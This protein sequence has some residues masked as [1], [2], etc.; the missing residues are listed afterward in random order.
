MKLLSKLKSILAFPP[1]KHYGA[2]SNTA[3]PIEDFKNS[4]ND[5]T[6]EKYRKDIKDEFPVKYF[7]LKQLPENLDKVF[8]PIKHK[9]KDATYYVKCHLIPKHRYHSLSLV[10][11]KTNTDDDYTYGWVDSDRQMLLA[12]MNILVTFIEE[13]YGIKKFEEQIEFL[14][15]EIKNRDAAPENEKQYHWDCSEHLKAHQKMYDI[16]LWWKLDRK[17][18]LKHYSSDL[19]YWYKN[20]KT[21]VGDELHKKLNESE[22]EIN[23]KEQEMLIE[24]INIRQF[25]W[26]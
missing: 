4:E 23:K 6:W 5:Y 16:Y 14:K 7:L 12:C 21:P 18:A 24:L 11:P 22:I 15:S 25:M 13:E 2:K 10:Q 26:T 8:Y 9:V 3:L 1:P 17:A 19:D 20:R